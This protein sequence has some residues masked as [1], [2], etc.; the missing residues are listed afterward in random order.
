MG[1]TD[2]LKKAAEQATQK[3][4]EAAGRAAKAA[5]PFVSGVKDGLTENMKLPHL[6][7]TP[8]PEPL[9]LEAER[10][11]REAWK[12]EQT[13]KKNNSWK[14]SAKKCANMPRCPRIATRAWAT[15]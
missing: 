14:I 12:A 15:A 2:K 4:T 3:A 11:A 8:K 10:A 9:D 5:E 13:A 7:K 1:L 6:N